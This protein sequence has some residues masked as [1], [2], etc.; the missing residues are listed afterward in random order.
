MKTQQDRIRFLLWTLIVAW[1]AAPTLPA[2]G[3]TYTVL[4]NFT[5]PQK[6]PIPMP[7]CP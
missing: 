4:H 6:K 3:Q 2:H 5:D 1:F 7:A